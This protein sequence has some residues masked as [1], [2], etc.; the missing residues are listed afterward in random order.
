MGFPC[1]LLTWTRA[2]HFLVCVKRAV[3]QEQA[4]QVIVVL[5]W[6][7]K[8]VDMAKRIRL[9]RALIGINQGGVTGNQLFR[10]AVILI[11]RGIK[12]DLL[13]FQPA[14]LGICSSS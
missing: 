10:K 14:P 4:M 6:R 11:G 5:D 12:P 3:E 1:R 2:L 9:L 13:I 7:C 8:D